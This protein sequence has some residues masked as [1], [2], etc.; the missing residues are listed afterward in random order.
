MY[1]IISIT[2]YLLPFR[3]YSSNL[4]LL[5]ANLSF[6]NSCVSLAQPSIYP[7]IF[8]GRK[9]IILNSSLLIELY[10]FE[11]SSPLDE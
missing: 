4:K 9:T 1:F 6:N 5:P 11:V 10:K 8:S 2:R 7:R 3:A